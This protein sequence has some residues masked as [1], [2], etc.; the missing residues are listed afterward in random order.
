VREQEIT[1]PLE[2][3]ALAG[4]RGGEGQPA[5]LLHGGPA[6]PD[7][8]GACAELLADVFELVR[9]TQRGVP[10]SVERPPYT[11]ETHVADAVVVL[12]TLGIDRAWIVGHS[13][14]GHLALH[15]L[16]AHPERVVGLVCIDP[17]GAYGEIFEQFGKNVRR[18]LTDEQAA[19]VDE[20][21]ARRRD[22]VATAAELTERSK[23]IWPAY[24][25]DP[26]NADGEIPHRIGVECSTQ[27]N[28][29]ISEHHAAA[30]LVTRLPEAPERPALFI[31]G[32]D[33]PLPPESSF[34]TARLIPKSHVVLIEG[35]GHFPWLECPAAFREA[36]AGFVGAAS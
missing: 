31:H 9:Y 25:A 7:Y 17:L 27:T 18:K 36:V 6:V 16:A 15:L 3:G 26:E 1:I 30:T 23:L 19:R 28:R 22:G 20:I 29:S 10:P 24:F 11:I 35:S 4:H 33:D 21:E 2:G 13:W 14:G 5:L 34:D 12:E 8:T 32:A